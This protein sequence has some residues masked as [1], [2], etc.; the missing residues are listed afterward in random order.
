MYA[1]LSKIKMQIDVHSLPATSSFETEYSFLGEYLSEIS[2]RV[3][4]ASKTVRSVFMLIGDCSKPAHASGNVIGQ[5]LGP[6]EKHIH[7]STFLSMNRYVIK[8]NKIIKCFY[9]TSGPLI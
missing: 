6:V 4:P 7:M 3:K 1:Q 5:V 8:T 2:N 9:K